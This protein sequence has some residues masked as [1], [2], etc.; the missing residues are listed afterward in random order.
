MF[1]QGFDGNGEG[2][3]HEDGLGRATWPSPAKPILVLGRST[4]LEFA[5]SAQASSSTTINLKNRLCFFSQ[6]PQQVWLL[7]FFV[8][9]FMR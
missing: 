7:F 4:S 9:K 8:A 5:F 1:S 6:V 2:L 3:G